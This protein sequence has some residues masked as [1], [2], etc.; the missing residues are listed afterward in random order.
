ML[1]LPL[2][3]VT[4]HIR[5]TEPDST[6]SCQP[7]GVL[8][9]SSSKNL[10]QFL[11]ANMTG[12]WKMSMASDRDGLVIMIADLHRD[13]VSKL[14][15]DPEKNGAGGEEIPLSALMEFAESLRTNP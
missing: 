14:C 13:E 9:F 10:F 12:E 3:I 2:W 1:T 7:N 8:A 6:P 4:E 11:A 15:L 5:P